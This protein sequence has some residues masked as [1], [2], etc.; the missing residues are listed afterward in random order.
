MRRP[1]SNVH[2][3]SPTVGWHNSGEKWRVA[4]H[5]LVAVALQV[6]RGPRRNGCEQQCRVAVSSSVGQAVEQT[7]AVQPWRSCSIRGRQ[8]RRGSGTMMRATD[9]SMARAGGALGGSDA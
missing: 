4:A 7:V 9:D 8:C 3:E 2:L 1:A 6:S 5:G